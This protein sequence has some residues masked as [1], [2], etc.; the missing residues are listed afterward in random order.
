MRLELGR[1]KQLDASFDEA[2]NLAWRRIIW[3]HDTDHRRQW[4]EALRSTY[5]EWRACFEDLPSVASGNMTVLSAA[6][7][8]PEPEE[9]EV[10]GTVAA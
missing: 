4:K 10:A 6:L 3:P 9:T 8:P 2:W 1:Y 5:G 7:L